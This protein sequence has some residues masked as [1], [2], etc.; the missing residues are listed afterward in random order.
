[1]SMM[2]AFLK[3]LDKISM[4]QL[5]YMESNWFCTNHP[6]RAVVLCAIINEKLNRNEEEY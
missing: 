6:E 4:W 1:M 3:N 5:E 2:E